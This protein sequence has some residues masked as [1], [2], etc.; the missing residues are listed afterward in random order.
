VNNLGQELSQ[1]LVHE[2]FFVNFLQDSSELSQ[3]IE[4]EEYNENKF[5]KWYNKIFYHENLFLIVFQSSKT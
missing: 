2:P 4:E 1:I 3:N 5:V